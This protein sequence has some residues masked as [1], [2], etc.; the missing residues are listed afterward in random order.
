L[1]PGRLAVPGKTKGPIVASHT[2][3][4]PE[5]ARPGLH[6]PVRGR[7]GYHEEMIPLAMTAPPRTA[8]PRLQSVRRA[9]V[10]PSVTN[11]IYHD[12]VTFAQSRSRINVGSI[13][14]REESLC[15]KC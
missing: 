4:I 2:W 13:R 8:G 5:Q 1:R 9:P 14:P 11:W 10:T 12:C 15:T 7:F 3:D 6:I